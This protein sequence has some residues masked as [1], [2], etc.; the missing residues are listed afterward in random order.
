MKQFCG[1]LI[2]CVALPAWC[3]R[4]VTDELGRV[5]VI[6]DHP[7]RL[8]CLMPSVVDDVYALGAGD[9]VIAVT[10]YTRYP[11]EARSKPSVGSIESPSI[12]TIL[13]LHPDLV[14][15]SGEMSRPE[16]VEALQRLGIPVFVIAP[17][18]V[19]GIYQSI[20][21]LGKALNRE[22]AARVLVDSLRRREAAVRLQVSGEPVVSVLMPVGYNPII[23]IGQHAF[24]TDLIEIAGGHSITSDLPQEWPQV[25]LEIVLARAPEA[26]LL[27][28]GSRMSMEKIREQP[29]WA[30]LP[31]VKNNRVYYVDDR[32][33][34]PSPVAFDA[35]EELAKQF[36]P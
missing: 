35:L 24:I 12:E 32:I 10:D 21:S 34:L 15:E 7:H 17:H 30:N 6:P 27:I 23:S 11:A 1:L 13:S 33:D 26:L 2:F 19:E 28:K 14:L 36:H 4:T 31:A 18:G 16:T 5:V 29:G 20:V 3:A 25:S 8:V 9:D 22:E